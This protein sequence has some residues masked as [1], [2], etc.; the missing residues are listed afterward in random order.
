[1]FTGPR[2]IKGRSPARQWRQL[3]GGGVEAAGAAGAGPWRTANGR[4]MRRGRDGRRLVAASEVS[5]GGGRREPLEPGLEEV[6]GERWPV[7]GG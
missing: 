3:V 7:G 5:G 4:W 1:V 6:A 2:G